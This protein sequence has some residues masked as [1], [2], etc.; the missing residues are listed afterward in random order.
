MSNNQTKTQKRTH[1]VTNW[2][3]SLSISRSIAVVAA[4]AAVITV[5][6]I[7][8]A[9][10]EDE[11]AAGSPLDRRD[12]LEILSQT[13]DPEEETLLA[14]VLVH[15]M[16]CLDV[17]GRTNIF[18]LSEGAPEQVDGELSVVEERFL[19]SVPGHQL[20][21]FSNFFRRRL[22]SSSSSLHPCFDGGGL[23]GAISSFSR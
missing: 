14:Q 7:V 6:A 16:M 9:V 18:K 23:L 5:V 8:A 13:V 17:E 3:R 10:V 19:V 12:V 4:V 21:P 22:C 20:L 11:V 1:I 15:I 2:Y